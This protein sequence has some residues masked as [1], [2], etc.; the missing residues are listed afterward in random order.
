MCKLTRVNVA[1]NYQIIVLAVVQ[2][3]LK[4]QTKKNIQYQQYHRAKTTDYWSLKYIYE[5]YINPGHAE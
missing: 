3:N 1:Y 5:N 2:L 4:K